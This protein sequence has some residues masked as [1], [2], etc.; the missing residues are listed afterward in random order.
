MNKKSK[1]ISVIAVGILSL[2]LFVSCGNIGEYGDYSDAYKKTTSLG[3]L[4]VEFKLEVDDGEQTM[5]STGNMKMNNSGELYY[6]MTINDKD[7]MQYVTDG[8]IHTFVD[9]FEQI[10]ST[11]DKNK[12]TQKAD[13]EG[14]EGQPNEK[15]DESGFNSEKFLEEFSGMLEAG[16]IKE[17]GVLDPIPSMYIDEITKSEENGN[18][19]YTMT[20]PDEFSD[21]LLD[22]MIEEQVGDSDGITFGKLKDFKCISKENSD[23][24]INYIEYRGFVPVTVPAKYMDSGKEKVF[25]LEIVLKAN[26]INPGTAVKVVI[27]E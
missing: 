12:G 7:I 10:S 23:G 16:K 4:N 3:S 21:R 22:T 26:I 13:P 1:M 25:D 18:V 2:F 8:E 14:G 5:S 15:T 19:V 27:P 11:D 9:G 17:M 20:F 6:E 24:Y